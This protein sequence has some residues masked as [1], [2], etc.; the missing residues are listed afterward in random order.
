MKSLVSAFLRNSITKPRLFLPLVASPINNF[1]EPGGSGVSVTRL[2]KVWRR[3]AY[4]KYL[5]QHPSN[6]LLPQINSRTRRWRGF[7]WDDVATGGRG[8][9][10][11]VVDPFLFT[12]WKLAKERR[13]IRREF[14]GIEEKEARWFA[15]DTGRRGADAHCAVL[16]PRHNGS[17]ECETRIM[18]AG[19]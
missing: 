3:V 12:L 10:V 4:D 5:P 17:A 6:P 16:T 7:S 11:V 13:A 19:F 1:R 9:I 2:R 8:S 14:E 18:V 15:R